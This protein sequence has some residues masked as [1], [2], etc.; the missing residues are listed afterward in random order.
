MTPRGWLAGLECSGALDDERV[1]DRAV[2]IRQALKSRIKGRHNPYDE[3]VDVRDLAE[4]L[5]LPVGWV[6]NALRANLLQA[7][8]PHHLMNAT[9]DHRHHLLIQIPPTFDMSNS[10]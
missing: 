3:Y 5:R 6:R 1:R 2:A 8:F 9:L 10:T 7:M 4:Q